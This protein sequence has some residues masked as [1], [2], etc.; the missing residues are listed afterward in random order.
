MMDQGLEIAEVLLKGFAK[1]LRIEDVSFVENECSLG[2]YKFVYD[3]EKEH[4]ICLVYVSELD[5]ENSCAEVAMGMR[6]FV[7]SFR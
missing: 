3:E 2:E 6:T 1:S 4:L 5:I 7:S